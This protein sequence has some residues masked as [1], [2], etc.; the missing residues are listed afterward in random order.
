MIDYKALSQKNFDC[1]AAI[2]DSSNNIFISKI[3]KQGYPLIQKAVIQIQ[4]KRLLD[5]G[6]GTG[7]IAQ[8]LKKPLPNTQIN[9]IDLSLEMIKQAQN[10]Q[11]P[12]AVF[13]LGDAEKLPYSDNTFDMAICSQS[14]HHYPNPSKALLEAYRVLK[15]GGIFLMC[16]TYVSNDCLRWLENHIILK[17]THTGDVHTYGKEELC[18]LFTEAGF[19]KVSWNQ[20]QSVIFSCAGVK[21]KLPVQ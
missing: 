11:L 9:G 7:E 2:Y 21:S 17:L 20:I 14:F 1:Q 13:Q 12:N 10:K 3:P 4:P 19:R 18:T 15:P 5:I 8:L 6:C 16:D